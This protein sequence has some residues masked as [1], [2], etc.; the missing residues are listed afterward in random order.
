MVDFQS[1]PNQ[2]YQDR[3]NKPTGFLQ[4]TEFGPVKLVVLQPTTFCNLNCD[5]CYLPNRQTKHQLS[6]DLLEPIFKN[7]FTSPFIGEEITI[8]WHAGEPLI[9]PVT[10]YQSAFEIIDKLTQRFS[11]NQCKVFHGIQTNGTLIN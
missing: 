3:T 4:D 8:V 2:I 10:Y 5:Y 7:L 11:K 1:K 9:L 6:L